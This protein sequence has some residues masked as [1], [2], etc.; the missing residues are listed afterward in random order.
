MLEIKGKVKSGLGLA[1]QL[2]FPTVNLDIRSRDCGVYIVKED[3]YGDGVAF[4]MPNLTEIHFLS[5]PE[6]IKT[7]LQCK[8]INKIDPPDNGILD[9]FYKGIEAH[10][11]QEVLP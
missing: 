8:V 1:R 3:D 7:H 6:T 9:Y 4:V 11:N 5:K 2:G 10:F